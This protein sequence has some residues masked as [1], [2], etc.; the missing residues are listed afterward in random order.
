MDAV[1]IGWLVNGKPGWLNPADRGLAYGDGLFETMAA[2]HGRIRW[3][4]Y[5][6]QRLGDGC[7]RLGI[8]P[9]ELE[10]LRDEIAACCPKSGKAV[11]KLIVTRGPGAR[12]YG[13][14]E[15]PAVTR[16]VGAMPWPNR[17]SSRYSAGIALKYCELRLGE[18]PA[19]AGLKHLNRLEQVLASAEL[20]D[21]DADEGLLLDQGGRVVGGTRS[22][23][24][25][26]KGHELITPRL[27]RCGVKGVMR[28]IV[29]ESAADAGLR[30]L[31][32]DL[33]PAELLEA[34]ALFVTN[35]IFGI[36]PV[37]TLERRVYAPN[38]AVRRLQ[39]LL[40]Y[41]GDA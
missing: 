37:R 34:D 39:S 17:P 41:D 36:W 4:E 6:L 9:P 25:A 10:V 40:G 12:G 23:V 33:Q 11:V 38:A 1:D 18:N 7:R 30:G 27:N 16:L 21:G 13:P 31:E 35:A 32:S 2:E 5:H 20:R 29:L 19:L 8:P 14:P 28:R 22:N 26:V 24:F 3:L 15:D